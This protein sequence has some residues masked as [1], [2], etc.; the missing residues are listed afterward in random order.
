MTGEFAQNDDEDSDDDSDSNSDANISTTITPHRCQP[1]PGPHPAPF[2]FKDLPPALQLKVLS[3]LLVCPGQIIHAISRLDPFV[4]PTVMHRNVL[5]RESLMHKFHVGPQRVSSVSITHAKDPQD[6]LKFL[7]VCKQ[8]HF[9][10]CNLFY[11]LNTF[12]FSSLGE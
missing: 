11:G 10:G 3:L 8:W 5:G 9:L 6:V 12:A 4:A 7:L 1:E 2:K